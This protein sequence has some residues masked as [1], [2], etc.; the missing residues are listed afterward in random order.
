MASI[1]LYVRLSVPSSCSPW[2]TRGSMRRGQR[3]FWPDSIDD[4]H[5]CLLFIIT[6]DYTG[7]SSVTNKVKLRKHKHKV[8]QNY[9][10]YSQTNIDRSGCIVYSA[11]KA[12]FGLKC[13]AICT[14][15][16]YFLHSTRPSVTWLNSWWWL[17]SCDW[18]VSAF[19]A[20]LS[21]IISLGCRRKFGEVSCTE[22]TF[23]GNDFEL[24]PTVKMSTRN[25]V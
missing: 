6:S 11:H 8:N 5:T 4:R 23:R 13:S 22:C 17:A 1:R 9:Y 20:V 24:I 25:P 16:V 18:V 21:I 15:A 10:K 7:A 14:Q 12:V 3:T 19:S 2:L